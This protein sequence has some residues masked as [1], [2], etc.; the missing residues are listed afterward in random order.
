[1]GFGDQAL[2]RL[3][4]LVAVEERTLSLDDAAGPPGATV[5][6]LLAHASGLG[7]D[8]FEVLARPGRR[9]IYSNAGFEVLAGHLT[10]RADMALPRLPARGRPRTARDGGRPGAG[11]LGGPRA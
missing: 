8:R 4:V 10:E 11:G 6:H 3:A 5:A 2:H 9:R 7:P 1:M